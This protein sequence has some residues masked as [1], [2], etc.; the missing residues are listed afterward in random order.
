MTDAPLSRVVVA[1]SSGLI[2][3]ALVSALRETEVEVVRLVRRPPRSA[4]EVRWLDA[5][6]L[7]P[8]VLDG[9]DAVVN[10]C[11]ASVGRIPWTPRYRREL[12]ASRLTPTGILA[13]A[14]AELDDAPLLVSASA[15]GIYGSAPGE[16]LDES[17]PAGS[18]FLARLCTEWEEAARTAGDRVALLRTAPLVHP[19]AVLRPLIPL[20]RL[21]LSG[22]LGP[23]TQ[24]WSWISLDDAVGAIV[25]VL[26]SGITGPVNLASPRSVRQRDFGRILARRLRRPFLLPAPSWALRA[27]FGRDFA[28][29]MLLADAEVAPDAL[30]RTGYRF[31]LPALDE[32][33]ASVV[34]AR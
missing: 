26:E 9:A 19:A 5:P 8:A 15:A 22:P 6:V 13:K 29:A 32:A 4:E 11:G 21:G 1:G 20:T 17:A 34:P 12:R 18:G 25:H 28:D 24:T 30:Q 31:A 16:R 33:V 2:G 10:L 14:I 7:D 3:G 23:G 27:A